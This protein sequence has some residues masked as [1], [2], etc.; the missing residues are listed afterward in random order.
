[1]ITGRTIGANGRLGNQLFQVA[2][3]LAQSVKRGVDV[4]WRKWEY[5]QYFQGDFTPSL[6]PLAK[7]VVEPAFHYTPDF[8]DA[9]DWAKDI[10]FHGYFQSPKYWQGCEDEIRQAFSF[11]PE[12]VESVRMKNQKALSRETIAIHIRR[13]DYV[14]NEAYAQ[15]TPIYYL[16]ALEKHFP[17]WRGCNLVLFSDDMNYARLHFGCFDNVHL[18]GGSEIEDLCLMSLCSN[19]IIANS[20]FSWWGAWLANSKKVVRPQRHFAGKLAHHDI[21]DLYPAEWVEHE[22]ERLDLSD[23]TFMVPVSYD[24][25]DRL[26][27]L[28]LSLLMLVS[29][30]DAKFIVCEHNGE[31]FKFAEQWADYIQFESPNF[32]RTRMLNT[33]A[34][35]SQTPFIVNFDADVMFPP[36]QILQAVHWLRNGV[37]VVYPYSGRFVRMPR[38]AWYKRVFDSLDIGVAAGQNFPTLRPADK[39][40]V[41]GCIFFNKESF[42]DGGGENE[43]MVSFS[44]DDVERFYRFTTLGFSVARVSGNLWHMEHFC[45]SNSGV[46][47]PMMQHNRNEWAKVSNM[48]KEQLKEYVASWG[49]V[50]A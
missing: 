9:L 3:L 45:G 17:D 4:A 11:K 36:A 32:H 8:Y 27:N 47:H 50:E 10:D 30:F 12:L 13:G 24:H 20:S 49:M 42:W 21:R 5:A 43:N 6:T 1:M 35:M 25:N 23:V 28:E 40:S 15:L 19:H 7:T 44:P 26:A 37:D 18:A 16:S 34:E 22:A 33:M 14:G 39:S 2:F 48:G 31:R 29:N 38:G 46:N 41:G